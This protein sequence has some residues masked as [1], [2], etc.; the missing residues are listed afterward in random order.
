MGTF[1]ETLLDLTPTQLRTRVQLLQQLGPFKFQAKDGA[2]E[3]KAKVQAVFDESGEE[4]V[5]LLH[6]AQAKR[7]AAI[8]DPHPESLLDFI[9]NQP[10]QVGR[11]LSDRINPAKGAPIRFIG[12]ALAEVYSNILKPVAAAKVC[13]FERPGEIHVLTAVQPLLEK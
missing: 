6:L 1:F 5:R 4:D 8:W 7:L 3:K 13:A 2:E 11:I 10:A 9:I 12:H